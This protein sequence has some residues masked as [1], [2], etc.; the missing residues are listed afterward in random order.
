MRRHLALTHS[1][2]ILHVLIALAWSLPGALAT[3][4]APSD[5]PRFYR[6]LDQ[7]F[8]TAERFQQGKEPRLEA[9]EFRT[10]DGQEWIF[11]SP[12][13]LRDATEDLVHAKRLGA[14]LAGEPGEAIEIA[15]SVTGSVTRTGIMKG[16]G[17]VD[18]EHLWVVQVEPGRAQAL[19]QADSP[20]L[21]KLVAHFKAGIE[22]TL[23]D[24]PEMDFIEL[25]AGEFVHP[26]TREV[27]GVKWSLDE[28]R[29]GRKQ[30]KDATGTRTLTLE[31]AFAE[32][33]RIKADWAVPSIQRD[34]L[35]G[36][37]QEASVLY[38]IGVRAGN[39]DVRLRP[40][41]GGNREA[42][43][44]RA[45]SVGLE[46]EE[47]L[48]LVEAS[49]AQAGMPL[50]Q[51]RRDM[52]QFDDEERSRNLFKFLKR[53]YAFLKFWPDVDAYAR[54][55]GAR[56]TSEQL[57]KSVLEIIADPELAR[58]S[59]TRAQGQLFE[60]LQ[61]HGK[62]APGGNEAR[63]LANF[64][65]GAT[66]RSVIEGIEKKMQKRVE[67]QLARRPELKKYVD[68][69]VGRIPYTRGELSEKPLRA[70]LDADAGWRKAMTERLRQW[71]ERYPELLFA[72]PAEALPR[73]RELGR[74][75]ESSRQAITEQMRSMEPFSAR[76]GGLHLTPDE[77]GLELWYRLPEAQ[78]DRIGRAA[79]E[80]V[81]LGA[82]PDRVVERNRDEWIRI[83]V[84]HVHP[85]RQGG[86]EVLS[87][88]LY[89]EH[90]DGALESLPVRGVNVSD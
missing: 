64:G 51:I 88:F 61:E 40:V 65:P 31:Q 48:R 79:D 38:R 76:G 74:L 2:Q 67:A 56:V 70:A 7:F 69:Q 28:I 16:F 23:V 8:Q 87:R 18:F 9:R 5:C 4:G 89:E 32:N 53:N 15:T 14:V 81:S 46:P 62:T 49:R 41:P 72:E 26:E 59:Q 60:V 43:P 42:L 21:R 34:P 73:V 77:K 63:W 13:A 27:K 68:Y 11:G 50:E 84:A 22:K 35:P 12:V 39:N 71:R 24:H 86:E 44:F 66:V 75:T 82:R 45:V 30:V 20:E 29:A 85:L 58:L 3:E 1:L 52:L 33:A 54:L 19:S 57:E 36:A 55:T 37:Y 25:K 83:P 6:R 78:A 47:A 17:D 90:L 80:W 10:E